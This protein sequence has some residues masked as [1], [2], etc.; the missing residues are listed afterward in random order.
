VLI[1]SIV[2][3]YFMARFTGKTEEAALRK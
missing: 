3:V 1:L 2:M